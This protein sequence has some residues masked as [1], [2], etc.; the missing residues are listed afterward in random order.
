MKRYRGLLVP[1]ETT[2]GLGRAFEITIICTVLA[3]GV[4]LA[5]W[6]SGIIK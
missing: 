6:V 1:S 2:D 4:V 5:L 3:L